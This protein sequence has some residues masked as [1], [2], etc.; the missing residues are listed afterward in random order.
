MNLEF[1]TLDTPDVFWDYEESEPF[2]QETRHGFTMIHMIT[3]MSHVCLLWRLISLT[4]SGFTWTW[5]DAS[6]S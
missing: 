4:L 1:D 5:T 2:Y 3:M 6:T